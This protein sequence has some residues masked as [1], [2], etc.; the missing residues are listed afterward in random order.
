MKKMFFIS[1]VF[2]LAL[3]LMGMT[4]EGRSADPAANGG[5]AAAAGGDGGPVVNPDGTVT[6]SHTPE[7]SPQQIFLAGSFNGWNPGDPMYALEDLE[8]DGVW[9]LTIPM[10]PGS[11]Q[12][13][14][15]IDGAWTQDEANPEAAPDGFGGNNSIVNVN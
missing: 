13:K 12:Y 10:D 6:F 3:V 4:C 7:G 1:L 11:Y 2:I 15:V 14:F 9:T 8:G 5:R